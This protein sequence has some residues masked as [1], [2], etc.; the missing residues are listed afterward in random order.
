MSNALRIGIVGMGTGGLSTAL[1]ASRLGHRVNIFEQ[2]SESELD[3]PVGA[4]LGLQPIGLTVLRRLGL[5]DE[6][7]QR[8]A[9][10]EHLHSLTRSGR[11]VLD[12]KYSDFRTGLYGVGIHRDALFRALFS[13]V[14]RDPRITI[15]TG[16]AIEGVE[17]A[18]GPTGD[19]CAR[20][21]RRGG[22]L[23]SDRSNHDDD[24][25]PFDLVVVADGRT[26]IRSTMPGVAA[27][28]RPYPW[29]CFW[30]ILPDRDATWTSSSSSSDRDTNS[31]AGGTLFQRL[32]GSKRMLGILPTGR[33]HR[34]NQTPLV[35]MFWSVPIADDASIRAKG[36]AAWKD[37]VLFH[38]PRM[39][40]LL[41]EINSFDQLI[42]AKY[43]DT[44]MP[45]LFSTAAPIAFVGDC[46]HATSPT[47]GQGANLALVDAWVLG[48]ALRDAMGEGEEGEQVVA[49][50]TRTALETYDARRKW[51]LRFYQANSR[52][53]TP[54]F[55]SNSRV[56]GALRDTFLG[57][58]CKFPPTRLQMLTVMSGAQNN[59]I[60]WTTIPEE[61]FMGC[62]PEYD[63]Q[64]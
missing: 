31:G 55:Q 60:P 22:S 18:L 50:A 52:M 53:L 43:C 61:E 23:R 28:Q 41:S 26:S 20:I 9:R 8:G 21:V 38:E 27:S 45:Q 24:T 48:E 29:G 3:A 49:T 35:S 64:M 11:A 36:L 56:I 13:A 54:V 37:E 62:I 19:T 32:D 2:T 57:P 58:L 1:F 47:L 30:S 5:M 6:V 4:G 63:L 33:P 51:R 59:G 12:L 39:A 16:V 25:P 34:E 7:V 46:A 17:P 44:Y 15:E 14:E 40:G 42:T 10:I